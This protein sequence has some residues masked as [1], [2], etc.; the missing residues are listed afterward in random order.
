MIYFMLVCPSGFFFSFAVPPE[1][2]P[3]WLSF[4]LVDLFFSV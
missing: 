1:D 2:K 3:A 4:S